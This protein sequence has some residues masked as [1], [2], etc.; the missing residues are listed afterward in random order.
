MKEPLPPIGRERRI[1]AGATAAG[2]ALEF[3]DRPGDE[4]GLWTFATQ[5]RGLKQLTP[6]TREHRN[7]V[8]GALEDLAPA[9]G[10]ALYD[11]IAEGVGELRAASRQDTVNSLVIF[12]DGSDKEDSRRT[13]EELRDYLAEE[14]SKRVR[15]FIVASLGAHCAPLLG[16]VPASRGGCFEAATRDALKDTFRRAFASVGRAEER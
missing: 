6:A 16:I 13:K 1:D 11:T 5:S 7:Q 15:V 8:R 3:A 9:G 2:E 10:T 4:L 12:S 14:K